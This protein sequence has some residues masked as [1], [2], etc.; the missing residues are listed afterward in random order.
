MRGDDSHAAANDISHERGQAIV[1]AVEPM[2]NTD[3]L[4]CWIGAIL[5]R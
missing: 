2:V 3:G 5:R 4:W 1:A